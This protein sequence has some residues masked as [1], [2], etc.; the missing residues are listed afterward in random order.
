MASQQK[1]RTQSDDP[2]V[3]HIAA[4]RIAAA[5]TAALMVLVPSL[6]CGSDDDGSA[7]TAAATGTTDS[8]ETSAGTVDEGIDSLQEAQA[9]LCPELSGVE[10]DL[11]EVSTSGTEAGQEALAGFG[12]FAA[13]LDAVAAALTSAGATD[14]A[15]AAEDL[16]ASLESLSTSG[17]ED[18]RAA[19]GEAAE[20]AQQLA[21]ALQCP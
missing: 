6:G 9:E 10:A 18:A 21:E 14:A 20:G 4:R 11:E 8:A 16:A 2:V 17:G 7:P 15:T 1:A 3:R 13:S 12:S 19:A 5:L